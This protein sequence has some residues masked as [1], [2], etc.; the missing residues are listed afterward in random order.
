MLR[1]S[2]IHPRLARLMLEPVELLAFW[3]DAGPERWFAKDPDFDRRFAA[4][5]DGAYG[6]AIAD[7]L[8]RWEY[9]PA[10]ALALTILLDQYPR[11]AF[12][13]RP[14]MYATDA[15]ARRVADRAIGRG[16]DRMV[17]RDLRV[18][19]YLPFA[20]S[21]ALADQ[22]RAVAFCVALGDPHGGRARHHREI[23]RR[24]GRFP[25]RNA[26]LGR[27]STPEEADWLGQGGYAG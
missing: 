13:G 23:V 10:G 26:I 12:R 16:F 5:F 18:F 19:Y 3:R 6:A 9:S 1:T 20:H 4:R 21:E 11:N 2:H 24:F 27:P 25:H 15:V 22:D 17:E 8:E 14:E 7:G